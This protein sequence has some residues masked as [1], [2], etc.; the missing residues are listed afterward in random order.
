LENAKT[1]AEKLPSGFPTDIPVEPTIVESTSTLYPTQLATLDSV[2]YTSAESV[3]AKYTE[4]NKFLTTKS[5]GFIAEMSTSTTSQAVLQASRGATQ[6][7]VV[8]SPQTKGSLVQ[9]ALTIHK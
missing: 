7:M 5:N 2:S 8:I 3:Q 1:M 9:I 4:Y 6:I